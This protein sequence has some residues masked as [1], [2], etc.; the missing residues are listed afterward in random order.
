MISRIHDEKAQKIP[1]VEYRFPNLVSQYCRHFFHPNKNLFAKIAPH[2]G[3]ISSNHDGYRFALPRVPVSSHEERNW[4][5][6]INSDP[7]IVL[8]Y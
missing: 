2:L 3:G 5:K 4:A 6:C 1:E 8:V 7:T